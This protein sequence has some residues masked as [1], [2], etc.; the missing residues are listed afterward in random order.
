MGDYCDQSF[1]CN[2]ISH[3]LLLGLGI[4]C[5]FSFLLFLLNYRLKEI[6]LKHA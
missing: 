6:L 5:V 2:F 1:I 4:T 3:E